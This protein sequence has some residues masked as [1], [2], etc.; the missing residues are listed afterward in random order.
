MGH[1]YFKHTRISSFF[2]TLNRQNNLFLNIFLNVA[3]IG[4]WRRAIEYTADNF[5]LFL[6]Q[7][8]QALISTLIKISISPKY[9]EKIDEEEILTQ[10]K[11]C[12]KDFFSLLGELNESHPYLVKRIYNIIYLTKK[13][14][15][16]YFKR[17]SNI[18][19]FYCGKQN[20]PD[21]KFCVFCGK[22]IN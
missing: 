7:N 17:T 22:N 12:K 16:E 11:K 8:P 10:Y 5:S 1:I 9:H 21:S 20:S 13:L 6:T 2:E 3:L 19:C 14:G 18:F 15:K 4:F